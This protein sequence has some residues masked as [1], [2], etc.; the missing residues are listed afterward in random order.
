MKKISAIILASCLSFLP[1]CRSFFEPDLNNVLDA[2]DSYAT[3][4][5]V[6][7]SFVGLFSLMQSV[8]PDIV[9]VSELR[10]DLIMPT[11]NAPDEYW[12]IYR[13]SPCAEGTLAS[14]APLYNIVVNCNDFL[15]N[16][17]SYNKSYPGVIPAST[18]RQM[19]AG[20]VALRTWAYLNIGK[21][22]GSALYYDYSMNTEMDETSL[23]RLGF[24]ELIDE[25]IHF[26]NT[27]VDGING[28]RMV[29]MND[30]FGTTGVW[31]RVPVNP[32]ALMMEL[33]LW[34]K[35]YEMAAKRGLNMITGQALTAGTDNNTFTCSY[36]FGSPAN[37]TN[38]WHQLFSL[39]PV[40]AHTKEGATAVF[41][42]NTQRQPNPLYSIF[43]ADP[44]CKYYLMPASALIA[45]FSG[46]DY[47]TGINTVTD[48]RGSGVTYSSEMNDIVMNKYIKDRDLQS[49]DAPVY[50]YRAGEIFLMIA[51]ALS[52]LGNY[53]A[54]DAM[55]NDGF[56]PY[57]VAGS[58]YNYPFDAPIYGFEKLKISHGVRGRLDLPAVNSSDSRFIG[59]SAEAEENLGARRRAVLDSI[60]VEE[61]ARELAGEGKRW[62]TMMRIARNSGRQD[63]L[64]SLVSRKFTGGERQKFYEMMLEEK[65]WFIDCK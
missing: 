44:N 15:R 17:I 52:G 43:S 37:G 4:S 29:N 8:V 41:Y 45:R 54:A 63:F 5:M 53:D 58:K 56:Q 14:P 61:T 55:I 21:I 3:R 22:Y 36:L 23:T 10:G 47:Q 50:V 32:D 26:M 34:K 42:D 27:G 6:Y 60:I 59:R 65:N 33:Y 46:K 24:D 48:P 39:S 11:G 64:A 51:E 1:S 30:I 2:E 20:T 13:Y 28:L 16:A 7:A 12:D 9:V 40:N 25:L 18:Y 62:F 38:Q 31:T 19:I 49:Q 57:W 35:D